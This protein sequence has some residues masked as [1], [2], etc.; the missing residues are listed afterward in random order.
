MA[1]K[2]DT[3]FVESRTSQ[4]RQIQ[5]ATAAP[6]GAVVARQPSPGA[7]AGEG[8]AAVAR[9]IGARNSAGTK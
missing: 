5:Q 9:T 8:R 7:S 1:E 3:S 4:E 6:G 2:L